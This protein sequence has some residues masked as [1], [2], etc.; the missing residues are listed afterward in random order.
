MKNQTTETLNLFD[1]GNNDSGNY[2]NLVEEE[3]RLKDISDKEFQDWID[4]HFE[5]LIRVAADF[6]INY[7][8][9]EN[10]TKNELKEELE[11]IVASK[12][13]HYGNMEKDFYVYSLQCSEKCY[14]FVFETLNYIM[15]NINYVYG[16][17]ELTEYLFGNKL[18]Q[19]NALSVRVYDHK[20]KRINEYG[21]YG[22]IEDDI[23]QKAVIHEWQMHKYGQNRM[24]NSSGKK[25]KNFYEVEIALPNLTAYLGEDKN[26]DKLCE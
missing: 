20:G 15:V 19:F 18:I 8:D 17:K 13:Y 9:L 14:C 2:V 16:S 6:S 3:K 24:S 5:P 25:I 10:K 4:N 21:E 7:Y 23:R 1:F 22:H 26:S 11:R 12:C